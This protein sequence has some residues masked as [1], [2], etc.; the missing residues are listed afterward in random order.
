MIEF[1][2]R[3][4]QWCLLPVAIW[5]LVSG[6]DDL[7][8]DAA[9][10]WRW[11]RSLFGRRSEALPGE[12]NLRGAP[13]KR[14][15]VFVPLWH[16]HQVI[17]GMIEHNVA[18]IRYFR[19]DVFIGAYPNDQP[20]LDAIRELEQRFPNVHLAVCPHDGPT[21]KADCL[22]WVFQRML[23]FEE[24]HRAR[25]D[26]IMC[27]DAEDLIHPDSLRYANF[28]ST[29]YAMVQIPVLPL[30]TRLTEWTHGV[31]CDEFAEYQTVNL[32]ARQFMGGFVPSCG[33]GTAI[34]REML[35][36][37]AQTESNRIFDPRC[38]TEDYELGFRVRRLGGR[39]IF[40][41]V[42]FSDGAPAATR[43]YFPRKFRAAVKQRTRWMTGIALQSWE[44]HGWRDTLSQL[45]WFWRDR[46]G[47]VGSLVGGLAN[48]L[49]IH[50]LT[51]LAFGAD[52]AALIPH[53]W[54]AV[55]A[56]GFGS[57][58][59]L[60]RMCCTTRIYGFGFALGVPVRTMLGNVI[61]LLATFSALRRYSVAK[62][63][64]RPLVW[65]KTEHAYPSRAALRGY[66]RKLG[67][68]LVGSSYITPEDLEQALATQPEGVR[69]GEHLVSLGKLT[70]E[71]LYEALSLQQNLPVAHIR[72]IPANVAQ[73]LPAEVSRRL[74]IV[75]FKVAAGQ[76]FV[77]GP[78]IPSEEATRELRRF[79]SLGVQFHWITPR[80]F[81]DLEAAY[82]MDTSD[83]A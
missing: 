8:V 28:Y 22:N 78:E 41:P 50:G 76:L 7:I 71:E 1:L 60:L 66:Q 3:V 19:Y 6:A 38:L 62:V 54:A 74:K 49:L 14:I 10:G 4:A 52:A 45:Y 51:R 81:K 37:I 5:I 68:I 75:P 67:E 65:L 73:C 82:L 83:A 15:A 18:A 33:V 26:V 31:Y 70:D 24:Q 13:Q 27:H 46:K 9:F 53:T 11:V 55:A 17:R 20:T 64:R 32:P 57:H 42:H 39:Q 44:L 21:S 43:E 72:E 58:R 2:D 63:R 36:K 12:A 80:E 47:L 16:E 25:F 61:N 30:P 59:M 48:L 40:V 34:T 69:L 79:S 56:L 35:E 77:A 23:D 29:N